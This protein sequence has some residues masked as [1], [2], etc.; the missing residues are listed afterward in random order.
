MFARF[1]STGYVVYFV[2]LLPELRRTAYLTSSWWTWFCVVAVFG[3][4]ILFGISSFSKRI[5]LIRYAGGFAAFMY[6]VAALTWWFAWDDSL[7]DAGGNFLSAFPGLATLAAASVWPPIPVFAHLVTAIVSM[8]LSNYVLREPYMDN[9]IVADILFGI[10]FCT[11]FV[12]ATLAALR[13]ARILDATISVT[14]ADASSS[15]AAGARAVERE[16]FDALI[17]DGVM[18]S[19]LSVTR[20]GRTPSVVRQADLTL[21]QLDSLRAHS[22][23][24]AVDG[25]E[26]LAQLRSAATDIDDAIAVDIDRSP[27]VSEP[28]PAEAVRAIGAALAE[29]LRNSIRHSGPAVRSVSVRLRPG[30]L[31]ATVVDDGVGFDQASVPPHRLGVAVSIK[32]RLNQVPGGSS[33]IETAP[34]RGTTVQLTWSAPVTA[35]II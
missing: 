25:D 9:P 1:V 4:G 8:Q 21:R 14:Q 12:A 24:A 2:L 27:E 26:A 20:Q 22:S 18:S 23:P 16:R 35:E 30:L 28:Y 11:I 5:E 32:G 29:A 15:A 13:T 6:L 17:H 33:R 7:F 31:Q 34:G 10:M 3:S 19:L